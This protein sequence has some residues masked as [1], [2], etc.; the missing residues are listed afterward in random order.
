V[1]AACHGFADGERSKRRDRESR[2]FERR[3][4]DEI[5]NT[6]RKQSLVVLAIAT[7]LCLAAADRLAEGSAEARSDA[8]SE[9]P[10]SQPVIHM[11]NVTGR[12][13]T[14]GDDGANQPH[15]VGIVSPERRIYLVGD[16]GIGR[17]LKKLVGKTVTVAAVVKRDIDGW[18]YLAV[19]WYRVL[20][21]LTQTREGD[22]Q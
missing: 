17:D 11:T 6:S 22:G 15:A 21:G 19:E 9:R 1:P 2:S 4:R 3:N 5:S 12:V 18:P 13:A 14:V 20:E 16:E 7:S 8:A 10:A